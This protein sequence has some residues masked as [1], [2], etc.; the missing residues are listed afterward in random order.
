MPVHDQILALQR[1]QLQH[2]ER[3]H[4]DILLLPVGERMKHFA[5]HFAKYVGYLFESLDQGDQDRYKK[6]IV[7]SLIIGL[8]SANTLNV[9]LGESLDQPR[10]PMPDSV[11]LL[12]DVLGR[13]LG[14]PADDRIWIIKQ[15]ARHTARLAKACESLDHVEGY[16]FRAVMEDSVLNLFKLLLSE[17]AFQ[18]I[19]ISAMSGNRL[20]EVE[21]KHILHR[22]F[23]Q[24]L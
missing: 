1:A 15:M 17:A 22:F 5:L 20:E 6:V 16:P 23:A 4:R 2:D 18:K 12:G 24:E 10:E 14:R 13:E 11:A 21:S 3:Y 19:N 9:N 8:A 7:D